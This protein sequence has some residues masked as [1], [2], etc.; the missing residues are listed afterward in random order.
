MSFIRNAIS[1]ALV[2]AGMVAV[3]PSAQAQFSVEWH[4]RNGNFRVAATRAGTPNSPLCVHGLS[5]SCP[6]LGNFCGSHA[7]GV[8]VQFWKD[9]CGR[10]PMTLTCVIQRTGGPNPQAQPSQPPAASNSSDY[11]EAYAKEIVSFN[12]RGKTQT[13]CPDYQRANMDR[14]AHFRFCMASPR[15]RIEE[16][17]ETASAKLD[18]CLTSFGPD[19]GGAAPPP[20]APQPRAGL[21]Y[22]KPSNVRKIPPKPGSTDSQ[23]VTC[24]YFPDFMIRVVSDGPTAE[25]AALVRSA[26]PPCNANKLA[27]DL[28]LDTPDMAFSGRKGGALFFFHMS[29]HGTSPFTVIDAQTGNVVLNDGTTGDAGIQSASFEQGGLRLRYR[30]SANATCS[31][32]QAGC[33]ARLVKEGLVPQDMAQQV[34]SPQICGASYRKGKSPN[35]NPSIVLYQSDILVFGDGKTQV[36]ARGPVGCEPMP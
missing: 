22:D 16:A 20:P 18:G 30:R 10:P 2:F 26:N 28:T 3:A 21:Q 23:E 27:G 13:T 9:G 4:Q 12:Q 1:A 34:P 36:L 24:T 11:C 32:M 31:I 14:S 29:S 17:R 6:G 19:G 33:W 7:N 15:A 8:T 25:R 35:D 5:C